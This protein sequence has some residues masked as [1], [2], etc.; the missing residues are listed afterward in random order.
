MGDQK[1]KLGL[2]FMYNAPA[3]FKEKEKHDE[4]RS[5]SNEPKFEWQRKYQAPREE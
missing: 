5:V 2:A 4:E 3:G 1:A